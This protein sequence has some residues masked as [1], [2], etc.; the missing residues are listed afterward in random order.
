[1]KTFK[2]FLREEQSFD[3][4]QF[5]KDCS[6]FFEQLKGTNGNK[7]MYRGTES[8]GMAPWE[9][10]D[11]RYRTKPR[12]SS[13]YLHNKLNDFFKDMVGE[14]I[15]NWMFVTGGREDANVYG[16]PFAIFPIGQFEWVCNIDTGEDR[17]S[18][19]F[20][21]AGYL[22]GK[23]FAAD[24]ENKY[25]F[26]QRQTMA[27]DMLIKKLPHARWNI[28][29]GLIECIDSRNEIHLKCK[30]YYKIDANSDLFYDIIKPRLA[31]I[32]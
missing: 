11:F 6:F 20:G 10:R 4:D 22:A 16:K 26:D 1:M 21:A 18:D 25:S 15:R 9:I 7:L 12:D 24:K 30:E 29:E 31:E 13:L 17:L 5:E 28:N 3:L 2:T 19:M 32:L 14:P 27:A 8:G 23:I